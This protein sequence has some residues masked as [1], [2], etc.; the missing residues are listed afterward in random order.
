MRSSSNGDKEGLL[1]GTLMRWEVEDSRRMRDAMPCVAHV[2]V[3][4]SVCVSAC[5]C[6]CVCMCV[7]ARVCALV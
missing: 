4:V 7:C 2:C 5:V 6:A 3:C 1:V